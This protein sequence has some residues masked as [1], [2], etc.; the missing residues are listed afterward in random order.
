[1]A[2][3][4]RLKLS[5][6]SRALS[7]LWAA[8]IPHPI[9]TPTAA[10]MIAPFVGMTLPTVAPN[11]PVDIR[12]CSDPA[13]D[14]RQLRHVEQLLLRRRINQHA[15]S[16]SMNGNAAFG[17]NHIMG[18]RH[19]VSRDLGS[20]QK[21]DVS[22]P[23]RLRRLSNSRGGRV[24]IIDFASVSAITISPR[25]SATLCAELAFEVLSYKSSSRVVNRACS[26]RFIASSAKPS[27]P[28]CAS[29]PRI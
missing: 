2:S 3:R 15:S 20:A 13:K 22:D 1:M 27:T 7:V 5:G 24:T 12:H 18:I 19:F 16:P 14:E 8:I 4:I 28:R 25:P 10:G 17:T 29:C 23:C 11:S 26:S 21:V 9:S 6:R